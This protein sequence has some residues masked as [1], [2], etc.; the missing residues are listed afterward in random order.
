MPAVW[1][2]NYDPGEDYATVMGDACWFL[3]AAIEGIQKGEPQDQ[4]MWK[5]AV[6]KT[7]LYDSM[8]YLQKQIANLNEQ[9]AKLKAG[10]GYPWQSAVVIEAKIAELQKYLN[11]IASFHDDLYK[12]LGLGQMVNP[13][14]ST[15]V[16]SL[17]QA[18]IYALADPEFLAKLTALQFEHGCFQL[19]PK[20]PPKK[21]R[22][23]L[24]TLPGM[25]DLIGSRKGS[26]EAVP[27]D[28]EKEERRKIPL[29]PFVIGIGV[30]ALIGLGTLWLSLPDDQNVVEDN[31]GNVV[32][33][34]ITITPEPQDKTNSSSVQ[35]VLTE[36]V[37]DEPTEE[38][39]K[40]TGRY[41]TCDGTA[42]SIVVC[43][44]GSR[45]DT[46]TGKCTPDPAQCG[47]KDDPCAN[48]GGLQYTGQAC[49]CLGQVDLV[50]ICNDGTKTD[51]ITNEQCSPDPATCNGSDQAG[52]GSCPC[53]CVTSCPG[54][55]CVMVCRDCKGNS[56]SQP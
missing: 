28:E 48:N 5:L 30:L 7:E 13:Y 45:T 49:T 56:C 40:E 29:I 33:P 43:A 1:L 10:K 6:V 25:P 34:S 50:I 9:L 27:I 14:Y 22:R 23:G 37:T 38:S 8:L 20:S 47:K 18:V 16:I 19:I 26:N 21:R 17:E 2:T 42:Y 36:E 39:C 51:T 24:V 4:I 55:S 54:I 31:G 46:P 52:G 35:I 11:P 12:L 15:E 44:D 53:A 41:C 32:L 3:K